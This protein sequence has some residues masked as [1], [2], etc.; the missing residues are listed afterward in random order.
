LKAEGLVVGRSGR[1]IF[2][3]ERLP[4]VRVG[5]DLH[6]QWRR[7]EGQSPMQAEAE[8]NGLSWYQ[9]VV[10]LDTVPAPDW[11]ADRL[12]VP[13]GDDVFVRRRRTWIESIPTQLVDSYYRVQDAD[14][15]RIM[16]EDTGPGGSYARLEEKGLVLVR[17]REEIGIRM[18][19]PNETRRLRLGPGIP[20]ADMY[21]VAFTTERPVEVFHSILAGN[22]HTFVYEFDAPL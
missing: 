15:T 14:G 3:R 10:G 20:V 19:T 6:A 13:T 11:V 21:R 5:S 16:S 8:A 1:G 22:S 4:V 17:F 18:P 2:V 12:E 7:S 9:E